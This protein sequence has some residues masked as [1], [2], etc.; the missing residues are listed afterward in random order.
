MVVNNDLIWILKSSSG[1]RKQADW[2][3]KGKK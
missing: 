2:M 3:D 1:C